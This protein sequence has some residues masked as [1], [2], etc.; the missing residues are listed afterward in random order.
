MK[1]R[2]W[3][4][5]CCFGLVV[6]VLMNLPEAAESRVKGAV[7]D[8][9]VPIQSGLSASLRRLRDLWSYLRGVGDLAMRNAELSGEITRLRG[10]LRLAQDIERENSQL[11]SLLAFRQ[12]PASSLLVPCEVIGRD[13]TGWW[14]TVRLDKGRL[15]GVRPARAVI[16]PDGLA[17]GPVAVSEHSAD[18]L[19]LSDPSSQIAVSFP[20]SGAYGLAVGSTNPAVRCS[21]LHIPVESDVAPG[22]E[23]VTSG[24][25]GVFPKGL[26]LGRVAR[27]D[28]DPDG[29][30]LVAAVATAANLSAMEYAFVSAIEEDRDEE[31]E[32]DFLDDSAPPYGDER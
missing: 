9:V 2:R 4:V 30:F 3:I 31:E 1:D 5:L 11:R 23:I 20:R 25:G 10:E 21:V 24:M 16:T 15:D 12:R 17:G 28:P 13:S 6:A 8:G 26:L 18:V 19:L 32:L 27:V 14:S 29:L 22:D 7:R